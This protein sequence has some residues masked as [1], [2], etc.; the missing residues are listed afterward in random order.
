MAKK[1][2][3]TPASDV[4]KKAQNKNREAGGGRLT[5]NLTPDDMDMWQAWLGGF[6]DKRGA[7]MNAF[8]SM[9]EKALAQGQPSKK[10]VMDWID[11]NTK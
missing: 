9:L 11:Q 5:L 3:R 6:G 10:Q 2:D 7:Q 1:E 4:V 8:R